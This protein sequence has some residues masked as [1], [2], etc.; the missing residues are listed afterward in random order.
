MPPS[1]CAPRRRA[2]QAAAARLVARG[3][4]RR[5][6]GA[7]R[8]ARRAGAGSAA[9]SAIIV[10]VVGSA[11]CSVSARC[12]TVC[13][14]ARHDA[15]LIGRLDHSM[16]FAAIAGTYTPVAV[17]ALTG[18]HAAA[19]LAIVWG[20]TAIGVH[21]RCGCR[22]TLPALAV[23]RDLRRRRVG[24]AGRR[25]AAVPIARRGRVRP[26]RRRRA[27]LHDR[28][29][30]LRQQAPRSVAA[31]VRVPRGV[32]PVH[33][34]RR[35]AA[36]RRHRASSCCRWH[37]AAMSR[38]GLQR[39]LELGTA[40]A[41]HLR[42]RRAR[43][44][45]GAGSTAGTSSPR[46]SRA[47]A[48][49]VDDELA[50]HSLRAYFIRRGDHDEPVR[51]EVDRIRNGRSFATRR[52]VARQAVGAI[53][54]LEASFQRDEA[55]RGRA[56][57]PAPGRARGPTGSWRTAGARCSSGAP[58]RRSD[59]APAV[60]GAG[61]APRRGCASARTWARRAA[62]CSAR[63]SPTSA[64]TCRSTPSCARPPGPGSTARG[65]AAPGAVHAPA[66]TTRVWFHRPLRADRWHLHDF[67]CHSFVGGRGL[68]IGHVFDLD[69]VHVATVA[70][71]SAVPPAL[72]GAHRSH[73]WRTATAQSASSDRLLD[74]S[75]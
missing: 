14:G 25:A 6:G 7:V 63:R 13:A 61:R 74:W 51:Y 41:G 49:T 62:C 70:Q 30:R 33:G 69:G 17:L 55:E 11:R 5:R 44:T 38:G 40:R 35:R 18:G 9:R 54:N 56:D 48:R 22:L 67:S 16:I 28:C 45:R 59:S 8:R 21:V 37:D 2:G 73:R 64:T 60:V 39:L 4:V 46:R 53:L 34:R 57:D 71:E 19:V 15:R 68:T 50:V 42:R 3:R 32:P 31:G 1:R 26:A 10:Y 58:C 20:G 72:I 52:V 27:G 47:A 12:T 24:G 43:A 29:R 75:P 23:H 66:W 36:P 65:G